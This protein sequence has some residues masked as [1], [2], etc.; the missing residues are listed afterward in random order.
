MSLIYTFQTVNMP[1]LLGGW[2]HGLAK[3]PRRLYLYAVHIYKQV[4][5]F[6]R[7]GYGTAL[8]WVLFVVI[9]AVTAVVFRTSRYWVFYQTGIG[10][11][12]E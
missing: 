6:Q 12:E 3:P 9:V 11:E 8:S 7:Y 10:E 2:D 4:F 5:D 1:L